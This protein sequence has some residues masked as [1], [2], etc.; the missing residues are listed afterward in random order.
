[1]AVVVVNLCI[2]GAAQSVPGKKVL[3]VFVLTIHA[4]SGSKGYLP[5][6]TSSEGA[7]CDRSWGGSYDSSSVSRR[8]AGKRSG[9]KVNVKGRNVKCAEKRQLK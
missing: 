2:S 3:F 1:M 7:L 5:K 8:I 9:A 6:Q 4:A